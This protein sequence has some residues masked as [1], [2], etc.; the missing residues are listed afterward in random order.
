M[1]SI[2]EGSD[3][4]PTKEDLEQMKYLERVILETLRLYPSA[5]SMSRLTETD[6]QIG[7]LRIAYSACTRFIFLVLW[8]GKSDVMFLNN[9]ITIDVFSVQIIMIF[10][11]ALKHQKRQKQLIKCELYVLMLVT[12]RNAIMYDVTPCNLVEMYRLVLAN[13]CTYLLKYITNSSL[14]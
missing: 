14:I 1:T 2:F 8:Y 7:E 12:I 3:R 10:I 6:F 11:A 13:C 9:W 5:S 4:R